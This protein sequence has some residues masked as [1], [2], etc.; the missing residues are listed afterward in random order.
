ML[1]HALHYFLSRSLLV[2]Y[3][4]GEFALYRISTL[5]TRFRRK[6]ARMPTSQ[7]E[8]CI[9]T[10][11]IVVQLG[12]LDRVENDVLMRRVLEKTVSRVHEDFK[13]KNS[14]D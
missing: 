3:F 4:G 7:I 10:D 11:L 8:L 13:G 1:H 9:P 2:R 6:S 5:A 14:R 12:G